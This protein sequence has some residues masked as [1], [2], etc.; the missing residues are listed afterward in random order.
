MVLKKVIDVYMH[1]H[2]SDVPQLNYIKACIKESFRLHAFSAFNVPHVSLKD[3]IVAGYIIPKGSYVLLTRLGL[4][5]NPNVWNNPMWLNPDRHL[6]NIGKQV[7]LSDHDLRILSFSTGKRGCLV[8]I[9][10]LTITTMLLDRMIQGFAWET[11]HHEPNIK[12]VENHDN[13]HHL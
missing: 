4:G 5:R 1:V 12:L 9:L 10:E 11:P 7:V 8:V 13:L 6:V 2:E 3:T